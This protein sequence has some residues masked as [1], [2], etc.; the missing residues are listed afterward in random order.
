LCEAPP[1]TISNAPGDNAV[2]EAV[3]KV[4]TLVLEHGLP[5]EKRIRE[6]DH[7]EY[8]FTDPTHE[9]HPYYTW[10]KRVLREHA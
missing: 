2:Q 8:A 7:P 5:L 4:A 1:P 3:R 6:S 10:V 9:H